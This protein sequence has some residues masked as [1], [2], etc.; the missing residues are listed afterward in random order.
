MYHESLSEPPPIILRHE[1][2]LFVSPLCDSHSKHV[3]KAVREEHSREE[4]PERVSNRR[5]WQV[6]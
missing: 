3:E 1:V 6:W 4:S 5:A 2:V